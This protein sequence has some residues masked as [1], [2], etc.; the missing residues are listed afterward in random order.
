MLNIGRQTD[1]LILS[2]VVE[3]AFFKGVKIDVPMSMEC[4]IDLNEEAGSFIAVASQFL[5]CQAPMRGEL[6]GYR[7]RRTPFVNGRSS[8]HNKKSPPRMHT[9]YHISSS[10]QE[11]RLQVD[12]N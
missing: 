4:K 9:D 8:L 12:N 5:V 3:G 6:C 7:S 10:L 1:A 2:C 11:V